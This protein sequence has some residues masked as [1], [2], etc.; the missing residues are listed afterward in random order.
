M[1]EKNFLQKITDG[2]LNTAEDV[3]GVYDKFLTTD[4][5]RVE[6]SQQGSDSEASDIPEAS[7]RLQENDMTQKY[8]IYGVIGLA[9]IAVLYMV[10]KK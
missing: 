2:I 9:S 8:I 10:V 7:E 3:I 5:K 6:N 4:A 1:A